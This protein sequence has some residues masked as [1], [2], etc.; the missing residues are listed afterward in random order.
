MNKTYDYIIAGG[1]LAG[2]TL[3]YYILEE[4]TLK[5]KRILVIDSDRKDNN[6]RTWCFWEKEK[7][8]YEH[9]VSAKWNTLKFESP[10]LNRIFELEKYEYKLIKSIDY[11][12]FIIS[13]AITNNVEFKIETIKAIYAIDSLVCVETD[14]GEYNS[15]YVFNSTNL[16][17]PTMSKKDTLLQ[18]FEGWFI[19]LDNNHFDKSIGTLMDFTLPQD[20][21]VTFMY[22]LPTQADE[23][24]VEYT[25]FSESL[26]DRDEYAFQ[27]KK[28]IKEKL[29]I[30]KYK[31]IHKE[32]GVI[33]MTKVKFNSDQNKESNIINIGTTGG[34]TKAS[35][36]YTFRSVH[37]K[38]KKI[39]NKLIE[40]EKPILTHTFREKMFRWYDL[41]LLDVLI[42]KKY[43]GEKIFTDLF[44][45]NN[46]ERVL[47]F[48]ADEST[49]LD[50]FRI[51]NSVPLAPFISSG[52]KQLL[53]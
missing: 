31:I 41:T 19:K 49:H 20:N 6:D 26:L 22:V 51:R 40:N 29:L 33:P 12:N 18:H 16:Y 37:K 38:V 44:K 34:Y 52:L 5:N 50:E 11:Y 4:P 10:S 42:E 8:F 15:T 23:A 7:E 28:Y 14:L 25:L 47:A 3:L 48:L 9:L 36:G 2:L 45:K 17:T 43:S 1:G 53:K 32:F 27:L 46:P 21:G 39:A 24:L 13:K 35:T 30:K